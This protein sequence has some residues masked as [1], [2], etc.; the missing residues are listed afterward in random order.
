MRARSRGACLA[1]LVAFGAPAF[2]QKDVGEPLEHFLSTRTV[3]GKART[4]DDP[5]ARVVDDFN[6]DSLPDVG[7]WQERERVATGD[8]PVHL[9][10]QRK[11]GRFAAG[12]SVLAD[13]ETIFHVE[14]ER[15]RGA[16]LVVCHDR[17]VARGYEVSAFIVTE[18]AS[19][20]LP[21]ACP[22][23][24]APAIERLDLA[25]FRASGV[26]AWTRR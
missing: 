15:P 1:V 23:V 17:A 20:D 9:Y 14:P 25:R 18:L 26:Q 11:D 21:K 19:A 5:V 6:A 4:L 3:D 2:A 13:A 7:L 8:L 10:M 16:R 24:P 12:G 22:A